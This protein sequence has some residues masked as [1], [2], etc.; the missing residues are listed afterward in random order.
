MNEECE[1]RVVIICKTDENDGSKCLIVFEE[2]ET[3]IT[4]K[5]AIGG[6]DVGEQQILIPVYVDEGTLI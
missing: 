5:G 4:G 2:A 3:K 6:L 1:G